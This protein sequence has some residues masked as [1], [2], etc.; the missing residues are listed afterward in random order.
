MLK[1]LIVMIAAVFATSAM[2]QTTATPTSPPA[3][4]KTKQEMVKSTTEAT[5]IP[6][7]QTAEKSAKAA[8]T[9]D[10]PK[11]L[12]DKSAKQAG[13]QDHD[14][15]HADS[16]HANFEEVDQGGGGKEHPQDAE[17]RDGRERRGLE[18]GREAVALAIPPERRDPEGVRAA[19]A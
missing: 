5:Q 4:A 12:T 14:G 17:A 3:D 19:L 7:K 8:A 15:R 11:Q 9:K 1:S 6:S 2:A 10:T 13:R 18:E 16:K